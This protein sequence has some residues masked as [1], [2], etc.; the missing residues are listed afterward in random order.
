[1]NVG[2]SEVLRHHRFYEHKKLPTC[3]AFHDIDLLPEDDHNLF[4]CLPRTAIHMCDKYDKYDYQ[5]QYNG[6]TFSAGGAV[7][8]SKNQY[9]YINGHPNSF[10]GWGMEDIAM[11]E[12]LRS[13]PTPLE[14]H[15]TNYNEK[16]EFYFKM[17]DGVVEQ[18]GG[19]GFYRQDKHGYYFQLRHQRGYTSGPDRSKKGSESEE[20]RNKSPLINT[21]HSLMSKSVS[22]FLRQL[23][24]HSNELDHKLHRLKHEIEGLKKANNLPSLHRKQQEQ[25]K[26]LQELK[27]I[28]NDIQNLKKPDGTFL[29]LKNNHWNG[30]SSTTY[31]LLD[32]KY[33][34]LYT[35]ISS[36]IRPAKIH[37]FNL[38][39]GKSELL[40][41]KPFGNL[42]KDQCFYQ[43]FTNASMMG[44]N[45]KPD[46]TKAKVLFESY[47]KKVALG[48]QRCL[49]L[50]EVY[51]GQCSAFTLEDPLHQK[52]I[53]YPVYSFDGQDPNGFRNVWLKSCNGQ[54]GK[55]QIV[56]K[57]IKSAHSK[58]GM[59]L[60]L[61]VKMELREVPSGGLVY[62]DHAKLE[63]A[64]HSS[65]FIQLASSEK[66]KFPMGLESLHGKLR[67]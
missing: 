65:R 42:R 60:E 14:H 36:D 64:H 28:K 50:E 66:F 54:L 47:E 45:F 11:A 56:P 18:G 46:P 63:G 7:L 35:K 51:A 5:T 17:T 38:S 52:Q 24:G 6:N 59:N 62:H 29:N 44:V 39:H 61:Q 1:M 37:E 30:L 8:I 43:K 27:E 48:K 3:F 26:M 23:A 19:P 57:P 31:E 15:V 49:L 13:S 21:L 25:F 9:E 40:K 67:F 12:R 20:E 2:Y 33:E 22:L 34:T 4:A 32:I 10:W 55:F 58:V 41:L 16:N 53:P